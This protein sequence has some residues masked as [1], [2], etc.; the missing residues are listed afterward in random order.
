MKKINSTCGKYSVEFIDNG[1][2][3]IL[4]C[5]MLNDGQSYGGASYWFT[6][7]TYKTL[8]TAI[9]QAIKKM[10]AHGKELAI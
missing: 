8:K 1:G 3:K 10:A 5:A 9:R 7:G 6:V 4:A 2:G